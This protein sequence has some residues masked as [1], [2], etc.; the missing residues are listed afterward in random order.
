MLIVII[1]GIV[2]T[3]TFTLNRLHYIRV[4]LVILL[5][6]EPHV[7]LERKCNFHHRHDL[8]FVDAR[9]KFANLQALEDRVQRQLIVPKLISATQEFALQRKRLGKYVTQSI[10]AG[11][12]HFATLMTKLVQ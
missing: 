12:W 4:N 1:L 7:F 6:F 3:S 11:D 9:M 5:I 2:K 10:N 8:L